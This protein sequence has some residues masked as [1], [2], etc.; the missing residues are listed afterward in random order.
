MERYNL[1]VTY[2]PNQSRLAE[3]ELRR[4]V[5]DIGEQIEELEHACVDGVFCARV[6]GDPKELVY[7]LRASMQEEPD[8][9]SH[10]Y[11]WVPVERWVEA[12]E[13]TMRR[14]AAEL[15]EGIGENE[16][17]MM[18]LHKR[19]IDQHSEDLVLSLTDPIH[20][21]KVS[22]TSPDKIIAVEIIGPMAGMS[23][24]DRE[25]IIDTNKIRQQ[26]GLVTIH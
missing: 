7:D 4:V 6:A 21:G 23:L 12:D 3:Q 19:H 18:H 11:H 2:H 1:L 26:A 17:W 16:R 15:A 13:D 5:G 14:T 24:L 25:E 8:L 22:L 10:T 9:L 20:V